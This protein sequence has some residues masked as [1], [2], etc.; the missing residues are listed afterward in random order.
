MNFV[1]CVVNVSNKEVIGSNCS[2]QSFNLMSALE[3]QETKR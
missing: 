2:I 3:E 1:S